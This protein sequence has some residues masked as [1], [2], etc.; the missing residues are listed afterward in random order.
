MGSE[1]T[2]VHLD[3]LERI[4]RNADDT[5]AISLAVKDKVRRLKQRLLCGVNAYSVQSIVP[6]IPHLNPRLNLAGSRSGSLLLDSCF[7][8]CLG[9]ALST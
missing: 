4:E 6:T 3:P 8:S 2:Y 9:F 1:S 5:K 7:C